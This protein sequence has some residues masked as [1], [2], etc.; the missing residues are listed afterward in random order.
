MTY[1]PKQLK[2]LHNYLKDKTGLSPAALGIVGDAAHRGGYHCGRD[3]TVSGDYSVV[4]SSRDR[5]GL[6]NAASAIDIGGFA[7]NGKTLRGLSLWLVGQC[8][9]SAPGTEDIREII[10]SPD[11]KRVK[12]WDRLGKRSSGDD[13]H[14]WHTHISYF[15]DSEGKDKTALFK[16]YFGGSDSGSKNPSRPSRRPAP[17]PRYSFPLP[18]GYYFGWAHWGNES[19]S[20]WYGTRFKGVSSRTWLKRFGSQLSKRG[21][22]V[23]KGRK[24]LRRFGNDGK[25]GDEWDHLARAF[26]R[27]QGLAVDGLIG[28]AT[29]RA[30]FRNPIT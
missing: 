26:Q 10:Y 28:P 2:K 30:A 7:K 23:G 19:I 18:G 24:Y 15:R 1:A 3:R 25:Y 29:W 8:R 21:W 13:S 20:G 11:G 22:P 4:E 5:R 16:R 12:R 27:D 9:K 6:S 14:L 17:K